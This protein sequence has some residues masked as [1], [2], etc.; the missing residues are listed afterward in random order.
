MENEFNLQKSRPAHFNAILSQLINHF[1]PLKIYLYAELN[2]QELCNSV[3]ATTGVAAEDI[4]YILVITQGSTRI[5]N[6]IQEFINSH[7]K[8]AV[9]M[10]LAHGVETLEK[11]TAYCNPFF[12]AVFNNGLLLYSADGVLYNSERPTVNPQ[13]R[14]A[15]AVSQWYHR[16]DMAAGFK[17]S[18]DQIMEDGFYNVA[19]FL[20]HQVV[21][22]ACIGM[23]WVFMGYK[24]DMHNLKRLLYICGCFSKRPMQHFLANDADAAL[25]SLLMKSYSA[26]RYK[27]DFKV[28]EQ[29]GKK[30]QQLTEGFLAMAKQ[31]CN[32]KFKEMEEEQQV[33]VAEQPNNLELMV[34]QIQTEQ[35][36][37]NND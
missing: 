3:F 18:I 19:V 17:R 16:C 8:E 27:D 36:G 1:K 7:Y 35:G 6:G 33:L 9:M 11:N 29:D 37:M 30:L 4:Y 26:A 22:Q 14:L 25:L 34:R 5:E 12:S 31:M 20:M 15:E 24:S 2:K 28:A 21:E 10:V 23:I 13:K 32:K